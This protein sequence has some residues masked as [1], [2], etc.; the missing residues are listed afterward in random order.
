LR[1]ETTITN[2]RDFSLGKRLRNLPALRQIG[3]SAN[4]RLLDIQYLSHDCR[5]GEETF[6]AL[7]QPRKVEDQRVS[8]LR[9]DDLRVQILLGALLIF[10]LL[11][12]GFSNRTLREHIAPLLGL[13]PGSI[14]VGRMTYDLR[15]LRLHGL[16]ERIP[17]THRYRVTEEG[18]RVALF[19]TRAYARLIRTGLSQVLQPAP[20]CPTALRNA[21]DRVE[22]AMDQLTHEAKLAA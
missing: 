2:T 21:F 18:L 17:R 19:F 11:P 12:C 3:F 5:I 15:R 13:E 4:R 9:F 16:I 22:R 20:G 10:R 8:A 1:T 14:S 6:R 7:T